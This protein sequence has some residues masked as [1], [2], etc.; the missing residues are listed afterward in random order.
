M[1]GNFYVRKSCHLWDNVEKCGGTEG[2]T[3]DVTIWRVRFACWIRKATCTRAYPQEYVIFVAFSRRQWFRERASLLHHT[4]IVCLAFSWFWA[5][6]PKRCCSRVAMP[7]ANRKCP[8]TNIWPVCLCRWV[9]RHDGDLCRLV[10]S[11][12]TGISLC[13]CKKRICWSFLGRIFLYNC[14]FSHRRGRWRVIGFHN[15]RALCNYAST[16][17]RTASRSIQRDRVK[18]VAVELR[19]RHVIVQ[20]LTTWRPPVT[21]YLNLNLRVV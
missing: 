11:D 19:V 20:C 6:C 14:E 8:R 1:F 13:V 2:A 18:W 16:S 10:V 7:D 17:T 12:V 3:N 5:S 4:Y 15:M 21:R 9:P